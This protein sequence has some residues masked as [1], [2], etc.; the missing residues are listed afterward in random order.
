MSQVDL[1]RKRFTLPMSDIANVP[2]KP[3]D[4]KPKHNGGLVQLGHFGNAS[5]INT[6]P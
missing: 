5:P 1:Q 4:Q 6:T 2:G 3:W